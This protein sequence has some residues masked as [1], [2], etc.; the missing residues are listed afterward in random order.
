MENPVYPTD[1]IFK[2]KIDIKDGSNQYLLS[3]ITNNVN[4]VEQFQTDDIEFDIDMENKTLSC[5][6]GLPGSTPSDTKPKLYSN[7]VGSVFS[8]SLL[9]VGVATI[10]ENGQ[11]V[12]YDFGD[13]WFVDQINVSVPNKQ[14]I[15]LS[16][17]KYNKK[18]IG[19][20]RRSVNWTYTAYANNNRKIVGFLLYKLQNGY[21]EFGITCL[22]NNQTRGFSKPNGA[23]GNYMW[24]CFNETSN[25][26]RTIGISIKGVEIYYNDDTITTNNSWTVLRLTDYTI[27]DI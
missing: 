12:P 23:I 9:K 22:S 14:S 27:T 7:L 20:N 26:T 25:D 17:I 4:T 16:D 15:V 18:S 8:D 2:Q 10:T 24:E 1:Y 3:E 19:F 6:M 13:Y 5:V 11:F 21:Y